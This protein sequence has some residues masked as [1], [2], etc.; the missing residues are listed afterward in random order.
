MG[1]QITEI[2]A[3]I[4]AIKTKFGSKKVL[5]SPLSRFKP[6]KVHLANHGKKWLQHIFRLISFRF[7]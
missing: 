2:Y 5:G 1:W 6:E 7:H 3:I 4:S